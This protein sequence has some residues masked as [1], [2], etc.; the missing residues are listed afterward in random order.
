M[1]LRILRQLFSRPGGAPPPAPTSGGASELTACEQ[2][3]AAGNLQPAVECFRNY[4]ASFPNDARA[5]NNLG[6]ALQRLGRVGQA[7]EAYEAA[8]RANPAH[9]DGW[10]NVGAAH[11]VM[12]NIA[13]AENAYRRAVSVN[14]SLAEAHREYSM[15]RL[16]QGDFS[17]D[18]W[19]AFRY[20]RDCEGFVRTVSRCPAPLWN[21]EPLE[22][23]TVLV[24]GEQ[25]LGD[26]ILFAS[27]YS[28]LI[29]R[30]GASVIETEPRLESLFSRSFSSA[31]VYAR[32]RE[33]E[34]ALVYP[35]VSYQVPSGDL[36]LYFRCSRDAFPARASFLR[37]APDS[38]SR[39]QRALNGLGAGLKVGI[40]W[41]GGT[42]R[43]GQQVRSIGLENWG[44]ILSV[45]G[46]HFVNLQYGDR[47]QD[48][49]L[50]MKK[51]GVEIHDF[52]EVIADYDETAALVC[53]LDL[54]ITVTTSLA[55]LCGGLGKPVW[56]LAN[57]APRW[58][59][60][61]RDSGTPWYP[62]ARIFRQSRLGEWSAVMSEVASSLARMAHP[63][64]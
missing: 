30:A 35:S 21:G 46:I 14:P 8:V 43:S 18:V 47:V 33:A 49:A 20:R 2:S 42:A 62:S 61:A 54:V 23:R 58:C 36:P 27:C 38:V 44:A 15:L 6:V 17:A 28:D 32:H 10:Y 52:P 57:A 59:Y 26:E 45:P 48:L 55:H 16:A 7:L 4:L 39:W 19:R 63:D 51:S 3:L 12:G 40:S 22:G 31:R 29:A 9:G 41:R 60:M 50:A 25:A 64:R 1:L 24:H 5:H 37:A 34:L 53:A 56:I 11:Q 13:A